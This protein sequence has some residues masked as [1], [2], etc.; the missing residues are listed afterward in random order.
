MPATGLDPGPAER[1]AESEAAGLVEVVV[2]GAGA[3]AAADTAGAVG[4]L[5]FLMALVPSRGRELVLLLLRPEPLVEPPPMGPPLPLLSWCSWWSRGRVEVEIC[6]CCC[7]LCSWRLAVDVRI[8][9]GTLP[10]LLACW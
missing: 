10:L 2:L 5:V 6:C 4:A 8:E 7:S 9:S 1:L 3:A